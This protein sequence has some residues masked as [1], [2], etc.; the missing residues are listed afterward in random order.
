M[1]CTFHRNSFENYIQKWMYIL[2]SLYLISMAMVSIHAWHY[3]NTAPICCW[4]Y[5][6]ETRKENAHSGSMI[7]RQF[8]C[9]EFFVGVCIIERET[10]TT[11]TTKI[12]ISQQ[13]TRFHMIPFHLI[14]NNFWVTFGS[15]YCWLLLLIEKKK[16]LDK[17]NGIRFGCRNY[18]SVW[19]HRKEN[20]RLF[21]AQWLNIL[22]FFVNNNDNNQK[23]IGTGTK[24]PTI[25]IQEYDPDWEER[26]KI[27]RSMRFD[28][29]VV[30]FL[31]MK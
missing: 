17:L 26:T 6:W 4:E 1:F 18:H 20:F 23:T 21:D 31:W 29:S 19:F 11:K 22:F 12:D 7:H 13:M 10:H 9:N 27:F 2:F 30:E 8:W 24:T 25:I 16:Q 15:G 3:R 5:Q 14:S 28:P